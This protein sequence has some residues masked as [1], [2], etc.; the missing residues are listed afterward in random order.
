MLALSGSKELRIPFM[1]PSTLR[2]SVRNRASWPFGVACSGLRVSYS[3]Y[4]AV[5]SSSSCSTMKDSRR[6]VSH[7]QAQL[8]HSVA[9]VTASLRAGMWKFPFPAHRTIG[10][11]GTWDSS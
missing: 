6:I 11:S 5:V 1:S 2:N 3:T 10:W 7:S 4:V 8:A 9:Q